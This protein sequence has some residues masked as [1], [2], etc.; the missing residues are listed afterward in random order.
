M[1]TER[2]EWPLLAVGWPDG[3]VTDRSLNGYL[4]ESVEDLKRRMV[5][6]SASL[7]SFLRALGVSYKNW[8]KVLPCA[9]P[10]FD[11]VVADARGSAPTSGT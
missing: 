2:D 3:P 10:T 11:E 8:S 5:L 6:D 1:K 9:G 4:A 7:P